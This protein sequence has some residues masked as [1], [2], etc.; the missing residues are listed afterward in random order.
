MFLQPGAKLAKNV[1]INAALYESIRSTRGEEIAMSVVT[2]CRA[3]QELRAIL[4]EPPTTETTRDGIL[5]YHRALRCVLEDGG[6]SP[7]IKIPLLWVS[8]FDAE[9]HTEQCD[10]RLDIVSALFNLAVNEGALA[11]AASRRHRTDEDA[12]RSAT[13]RFQFAAGFLRAAAALPTPGGVRSVT[14]DLWPVTLHA[15]E[16]VMLGNAQQAFFLFCQENG[17]TPSLLARLSSGAHEFYSV[18]ADIC[19]DPDVSDSHVNALVGRPASALAAYCAAVAQSC[20]AQALHDSG[21]VAQEILR[22]RY[23]RDATSAAFPALDAVDASTLAALRPLKED[24]LAALRSLADDVANRLESA[25]EE[26]RKFYL[27]TIPTSLP[28]IVPH[29]SVKAA[30][31][32]KVLSSASLDERILPFADLPPVPDAA[33]TGVAARYAEAAAHLVAEHVAKLNSAAADATHAASRISR[34]VTSA[35]AAVSTAATKRMQPSQTSLSTSL[36]EEEHRAVDVLKFAK[37]RGGIN[38]LKE[39]QAQVLALADQTHRDI[40]DIEK[41]LRDEEEQDRSLRNY[42]APRR[43]NSHQLTTG[44][45]AKLGKLRTNLEQAANADAIVSNQVQVH[46]DAITAISNLDVD[47]A[48]TARLDAS[49]LSTPTSSAGINNSDVDRIAQEL[50]DLRKESET[51]CARKNNVLHQLELVKAKDNALA[52]TATIEEGDEETE[53]FSALLDEKYGDVKDTAINLVNDLENIAERITALL[54]QLQDDDVRSADDFANN[55]QDEGTKK[56]LEIFKH[57][58]AAMKFRE[59]MDHLHQG[60]HFYSKEQENIAS[61]KKEVKDFITA[62][63]LEYRN[64]LSNNNPDKGQGFYPQSTHSSGSGPHGSARY[65]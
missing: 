22:L 34:A 4:H 20:A 57:Q 32:E 53:R 51:L 45:R 50:E 9:A 39:L 55:S 60:I 19:R 43:Q 23:T 11:I 28:S 1:N 52:A 33:A 48:V 16:A 3:V 30:D 42:V 47:A 35:R 44:Y 37:T 24:L 62:R 40:D 15:L 46:S 31:I 54:A 6:V 17:T 8:A 12:L 25:E 5:R 27:E 41:M 10:L 21:N 65:S 7:N 63:D 64:H 13:K 14:L 56:M 61:L 18:A 49:R 26:N 58:A 29:Q 59:T 36:T 2:P 38:A